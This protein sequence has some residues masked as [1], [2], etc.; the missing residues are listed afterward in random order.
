MVSRPNL[1]QW[2]PTSWPVS[3][4]WRL[5]AAV[6]VLAGTFVTIFTLSR[7]DEPVMAVPVVAAA[8]RWAEGHPPGEHVIV[9]VPADLAVLFVH[10]TELTDIVVAV[11]VPEG[12]LISPQML[13]QRQDSDSARATALMQFTVSAELWPDPGPVTGRRAVF[14]PSPGGCSVALVALLA[15]AGDGNATLVTVEADPELAAVLSD[16]QWWIW[17]SPPSGWPRCENEEIG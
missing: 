3:F 2:S 11:D 13:R 1:E 17:E 5:L 9:D 6:V 14:S 12:T 15:V 16:K 10:P 8:Q 4:K 7:R